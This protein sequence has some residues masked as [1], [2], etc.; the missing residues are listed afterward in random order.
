MKSIATVKRHMWAIISAVL[1]DRKDCY[2]ERD[3]LAIATF[4]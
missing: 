1:V 2:A 3:L 4:L